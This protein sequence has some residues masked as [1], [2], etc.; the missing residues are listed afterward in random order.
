MKER[1]IFNDAQQ[2]RAQISALIAKHPEMQEDAELMADMLEGETSLYE[3]LSK[4][5]D[6]RQEAEVMQEAIKARASDMNARAARYGAKSDTMKRIMLSLMEAAG[7]RKIELVEATLSINKGRAKVEVY[8]ID[9]LPQG[10]YK[11]ERVADK[12]AI[13]AQIDAGEVIPGAEKITGDDS[14]TVRSK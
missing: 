11:T 7:Q 14:L 2:V 12:K 4:C 6:V 10:T 13:L 1:Y 5:L 9:A 8:D 3:I